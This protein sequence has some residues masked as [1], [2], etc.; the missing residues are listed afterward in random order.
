M[1]VSGVWG[2]L[3]SYKKHIAYI[4]LALA[5][6]YGAFSVKGWYDEQILN[7]YNNGVTVT[8]QKWEKENSKKEKETQKFKDEQERKRGELEAEIT[9]LKLENS[10]DKNNGG[11]KKDAYIKKPASKEKVLDD[12]F[13]EIYNDSLRVK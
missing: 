9:R 3:T 13:V 2:F 11:E 5:L 4:L 8:D 6:F 10:N 1:T 12:D 7:S